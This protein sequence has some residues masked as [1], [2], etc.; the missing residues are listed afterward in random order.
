MKRGFGHGPL[1]IAIALLSGF[2][3][4][5]TLG[6][7]APLLEAAYGELVPATRAAGME[8]AVRIAAK[9]CAPGRA[10]LLSPGCAS[11]DMYGDFEERGEDFKSI[12]R[13]LAEEMELKSATPP[14]GVEDP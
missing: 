3:C 8:D 9:A 4:P 7:D 5:V 6:Q 12:V 1:R 13:R 11:F 10:V 2:V 14:I